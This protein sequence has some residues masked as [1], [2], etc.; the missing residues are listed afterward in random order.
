MPKVTQPDSNPGQT[1]EDSLFP[2][3]TSLGFGL[4][5]CKM[6]TMEPPQGCEGSVHRA[7]GA[8]PAELLPPLPDV[9]RWLPLSLALEAH[10][11]ALQP[12]ALLHAPT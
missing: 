6:S 2:L 1:P 11:P 8:Q 5:A 3:S 10:P 7:A 4:L 12:V 9:L